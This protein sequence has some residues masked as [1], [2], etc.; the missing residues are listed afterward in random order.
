MGPDFSGALEGCPQCLVE[1]PPIRATVEVQISC[2]EDP[3]RGTGAA[4]AVPGGWEPRPPPDPS[5][6]FCVLQEE[7][8]CQPI[9]DISLYNKQQNNES[10]LG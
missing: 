2:G 5:S 8:S 10:T 6:L 7:H 4:T 3:A 1:A 9:S